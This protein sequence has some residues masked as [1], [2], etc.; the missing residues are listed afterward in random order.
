M[1]ESAVDFSESKIRAHSD[2]VA[3]PVI[4]IGGGP[5]GMML[6]LNLDA[7]GI[8]CIMV[9]TQLRPQQHPKGGTHNS[10]TME[11]YRRLGLADR[12]RKLGLPPD[13]P[14]DVVYFT[15]MNGWELQRIA[16]PSELEKQRMVAA[17][18]ATDQVPEPILRCNQMQV[19]ALVFDH[20]TTRRNIVLRY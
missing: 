15:R 7:L 16:M 2:V 9:N 4:I 13:H 18:A 3:A 6:A 20:V 17:A 14:T 5:V 12:I 19:E 1:S 8:R 10:R 11:H